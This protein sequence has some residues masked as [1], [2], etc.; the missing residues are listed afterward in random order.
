M[1]ARVSTLQ[2]APEGLDAGTA[3]V[4]DQV[5]PA[6]REMNGFKGMLAFGDRA[7]GKMIGITLWDSEDAMR[8]SEASADQLRSGAAAAG[9]SNIVNVERFEVVVNET[10]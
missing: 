3:A 2:G 1:F 5:L 9:A 4:R 7:T 8:A 6:A 10:L